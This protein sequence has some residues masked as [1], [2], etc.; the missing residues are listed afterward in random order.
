MSGEPKRRRGESQSGRKYE[1]PQCGR[2]HR[3]WKRRCDFWTV[4]SH[5]CPQDGWL[6]HE[7]RIHV[8]PPAPA[9]SAWAAVEDWLDA[10]RRMV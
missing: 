1:C 8:E 2:R 4:Y 7:V 6:V 9:A 5:R 10:F 3:L